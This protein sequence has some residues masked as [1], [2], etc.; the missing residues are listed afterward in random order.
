MLSLGGDKEPQGTLG[1][2]GRAY[3]YMLVGMAGFEPATFCFQN[4]PSTRLTLHPV[5]LVGHLG[6][7]PSKS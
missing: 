4:R 6:I 5:K 3:G 1:L 7:E 2:R